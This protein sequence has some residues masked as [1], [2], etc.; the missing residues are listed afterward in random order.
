MEA[1]QIAITRINVND[2]DRYI[3]GAITPHYFV[4]PVVELNKKFGWECEIIFPGK[5]RE[6][7][8]LQEGIR[9][10]VFPITSKWRDLSLPLIRHANRA[11]GLLLPFGYNVW[12]SLIPTKKSKAKKFYTTAFERYF[13]RPPG[14]WIFKNIE[15]KYLEHADIIR[16]FTPWEKAELE[17][18]VKKELSL[19]PLGIRTDIADKY[20]RPKHGERFRFFTLCR[21]DDKK[22]FEMIC[23]VWKRIEDK[24]DAEWVIAG[25]IENQAYF[26]RLKAILGGSKNVKFLGFLGRDDAIK[27]MLKSDVYIQTSR[28]E[29]FPS[30]PVE[31]QTF[32]LPVITTNVTGMSYIIKDGYSGILVGLDDDEALFR[33]MSNMI[34]NDAIRKQMGKNG[35]KFVK[36]NFDYSKVKDKFI[37]MVEGMI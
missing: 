27:E 22:N 23:R 3:K 10:E 34:E 5:K 28:S 8:Q 7:I 17:K 21:I 25:N 4:W 26:S 6:T 15:A 9:A 30:S 35:M 13:G 16:V 12:N 31:A 11:T 19:L 37:H 1:T 32:G 29:G 33:A 18:Y 20:E 36:E 2:W 14:H 24:Y